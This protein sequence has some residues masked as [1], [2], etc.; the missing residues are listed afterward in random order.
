MDFTPEEKQLLLECLA[1]VNT[2]GTNWEQRLK[3]LYAKIQKSIVA[4]VEPLT[5]EVSLPEND[6]LVEIPSEDS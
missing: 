2:N 6:P 1:N 3:P 5:E 4:P